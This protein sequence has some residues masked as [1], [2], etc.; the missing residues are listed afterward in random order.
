MIGALFAAAV[1]A[2]PIVPSFALSIVRD[3]APWRRKYW[4]S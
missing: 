4:A 3:G 2:V 1:V